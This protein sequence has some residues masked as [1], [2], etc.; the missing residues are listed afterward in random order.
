MEAAET[1]ENREMEGGGANTGRSWDAYEL[2]IAW[3]Q[4]RREEKYFLVSNQML[5]DI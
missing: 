1:S 5:N 2:D 3:F 4:A